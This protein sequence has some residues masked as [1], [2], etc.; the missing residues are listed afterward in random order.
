[1]KTLK[2]TKF[3]EQEYRDEAEAQD[4]DAASVINHPLLSPEELFAKREDT[5]VKIDGEIDQ[6]V[7]PM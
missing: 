3:V 7:R 2:E 4:I 1:M 5:N 6:H